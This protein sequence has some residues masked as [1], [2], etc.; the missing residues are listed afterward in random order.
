RF[1]SALTRP[2]GER[3]GAARLE[4]DVL[5]ELAAWLEPDD[6]GGTARPRLCL[7]LDAPEPGQD[8]RW[9]LSYY[10]QAPDDPSLLLPAARAWSTSARH[11][12]WMDKGFAAP[13][14]TLLQRLAEAAR[15][16]APIER[17]LEAPRPESVVLESEEAWRFIAEGAPLLSESG[18]AVLLPAE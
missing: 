1:A 11:L 7:K 13:Q 5:D 2:S 14:E 10:L 4:P 17:S 9:P 16:F 15:L 8:A 6:G 12:Q 18:H 3:D